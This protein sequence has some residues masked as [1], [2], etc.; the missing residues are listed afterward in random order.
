MHLKKGEIIDNNRLT[1]I[2]V[3]FHQQNQSGITV[4]EQ[5]K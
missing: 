2:N 1:L 4:L 3:S 5:Y